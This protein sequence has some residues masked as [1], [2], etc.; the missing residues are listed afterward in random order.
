MN[1]RDEKLRWEY[2]KYEIRKF[3]IRFSKN[4]AKK[5][6]KGAQS[7]REK[8]KYLESSVTTHHN[9]LQYIEYKGR[10]N[11]IYSEK[12]NEIRISSK[13]YWY[14]SGK[15]S[16]KFFLNLEQ[17]RSTQSVV[18]HCILKN[19]TEE[20]NQSEINNELYKFYKNLF[21]EN[22]NTSKE[23]IFSFLEN[24][25][26]PTLTSKQ[27]LECERIIRQT[28]LLKTLKSTKNDKSAGNVGIKKEFHEFFWDDI[29]NSLSDSIKKS[30]LSGELS[31]F[32]KQAAIKLIEKKETDKPLIKYWR[33]ISSLNIDT[34]LVSK[35]KAIRLK[36]ILNNLIS[37]N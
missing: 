12:V 28:E 32:Q 6:R 5:V 36:K 11:I 7:L 35:V 16:T 17:S 26:L 13:F 33:P 24:V 22:L 10:L 29:K 23:A 1:V 37:E 34:K 8:V 19:K 20:E 25:N 2:L 31:T 21:K 4:L 9:N 18:V 27:A 3:F 15:K 30:F 14:K